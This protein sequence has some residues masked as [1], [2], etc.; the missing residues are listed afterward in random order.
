MLFIF[1]Y[2]YIAIGI[3]IICLY[4]NF[5]ESKECIS[6]KLSQIDCFDKDIKNNLFDIKNELS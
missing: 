4:L 6:L 2:L 1:I 3:L 5:I